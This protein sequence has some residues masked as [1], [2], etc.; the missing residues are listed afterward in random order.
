[1]NRNLLFLLAVSSSFPSFAE[2]VKTPEI[3]IAQVLLPLAM[4]IGLIF[5]LAWLV[6][7]FHPGTPGMG[8]GV[9]V[10]A[11][12]PLSS[13]ARVCLVRVGGKDVLLGVTNQQVS[14]LLVLEETEE[15]EEAGQQPKND[16]ADHFKRLLNRDGSDAQ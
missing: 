7:R 1:M 5:A 15:V 11:N 2:G 4:V 8:K 13:Q 9:Q 16:F 12:T 14:R 10:L 3:S 6:K